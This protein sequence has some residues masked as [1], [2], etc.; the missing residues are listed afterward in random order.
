MSEVRARKLGRRQRE[1]LAL[2]KEHGTYFKKCGWKFN[3][4]SET[5]EI[6][7]S[8]VPK[9]YVKTSVVEDNSLLYEFVSEPSEVVET[10]ETPSGD[11]TETSPEADTQESEVAEQAPVEDPVPA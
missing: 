8:L 6:L 4:H 9:G 2:L 1:A 3:S 7:E 11:S 10:V 5:I